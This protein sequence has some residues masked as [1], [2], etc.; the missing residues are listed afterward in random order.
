M[1][2]NNKFLFAALLFISLSMLFNFPFPHNH[3]FGEEILYLVN[4]P[5]T[6]S[7]GFQFI[8]ILSFSFLVVGVFFLWHSFDKYKGR[9]TILALVLSLLL[10]TFL[11][12]MFQRTIAP[13]I[14][15]VSYQKDKSGC[16]FEKINESMIQAECDLFFENHS[17]KDVFFSIDFNEEY[18]Y[19]ENQQILELM[20][21][22]GTYSVRLE[23]NEFK[24][25]NIE[26]EIEIV[27]LEKI[28]Y[29]GSARYIPLKI[30]SG[31]IVREL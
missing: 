26:S 11:V 9:M 17:G 5:V 1:I 29:T 14:Y 16:S 4:I 27:N 30:R 25:V 18:L 3:P 10:P 8:G 12:Y 19:E 31:K 13:G 20:N 22:I 24:V 6:N 2:K 7:N 21:K 15:A 28:I 23:P